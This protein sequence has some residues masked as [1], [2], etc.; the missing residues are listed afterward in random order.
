[1]RDNLFNKN[2][3]LIDFVFDKQ[4]VSVFDDMVK[5]SVPGYLSMLEMLGLMVKIYAQDNTNFYD[6]GASTGAAS[7]AIGINNTCQNNKIICVDNAV[8]MTLQCQNNLNGKIADFEVICANIEDIC[9]EQASIV[10]LN[11]TLQFIKKQHRQ[12]LIDKIYQGLNKGGAL[13]VSE[14]IY[15][16]NDKQQQ[17]NSLHLNFKRANGY[18]ELE[19]AN[20]RQLLE[21]VLIA[22][23][24]SAHLQ[25]FQDAG[26]R[27]SNCYFQCLNFASFLAVK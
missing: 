5:R 18:S 10:V 1:M 27:E 12:Q 24:K 3:D 20:K 13:I 14:K 6:L 8:D 16:N 4:V 7:L 9:I 2:N 19:I 23:N 22:E 15:F 25:R 17:I 26:F 21:N 11:L